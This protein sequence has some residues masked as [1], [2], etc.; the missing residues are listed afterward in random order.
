MEVVVV[1]IPKIVLAEI[2]S[3]ST[4]TMGWFNASLR[5]AW[6]FIFPLTEVSA[7]EGWLPLTDPALKEA[8]NP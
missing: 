2:H 3:N 1:E 7:K 8:K 5:K 4:H 6:R